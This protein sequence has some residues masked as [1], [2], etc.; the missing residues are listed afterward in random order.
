ML[1]TYFP[2]FRYV[3]FPVYW[4]TRI[5]EDDTPVMPPV[6]KDSTGGSADLGMKGLRAYALYWR[7]V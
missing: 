3:Y 7:D 1:A 4:T 6:K 2:P 5:N